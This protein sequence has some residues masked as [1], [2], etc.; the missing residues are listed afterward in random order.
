VT[1]AYSQGVRLG[2]IPVLVFLLAADALLA[3]WLFGALFFDDCEGEC[4]EV[5]AWMFLALLA[6][7]L[8]VSSWATW[9]V[10]RKL[11][12]SVRGEP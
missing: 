4:V 10:A 6:A 3:V 2:L 1:A 5:L 9:R 12:D 8:L 7:L 11:R